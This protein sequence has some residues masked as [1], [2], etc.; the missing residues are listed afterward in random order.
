MI[1]GVD[2]LSR[3]V[4]QEGMVKAAEV[5]Q[6]AGLA[7]R[8]DKTANSQPACA[9]RLLRDVSSC[10]TFATQMTRHNRDQVQR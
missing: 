7:H 2:P 4:T 8:L 9:K 6:S 1:S 10:L 3:T 5:N